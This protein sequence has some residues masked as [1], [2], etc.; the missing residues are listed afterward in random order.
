MTA[1]PKTTPPSMR[2]EMMALD[3]LKRAA[4]NPKQ[5]N[6][7]AISESMRRFDF[8]APLAIN[9]AT[10]RLVA[11]HGRLDALEQFRKDGQPPPSA[12]SGRCAGALAG[13]R[14]PWHLLRE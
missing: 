1:R 4:R 12:G 7:S 3:D 11:G 9:E 13:A 14:D 10:G 8:V 6:L 5:H 2:I